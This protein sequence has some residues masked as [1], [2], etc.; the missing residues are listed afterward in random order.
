MKAIVISY[1]PLP[2]FQDEIRRKITAMDYGEIFMMQNQ[3]IALSFTN[4]EL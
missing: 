3:A 2:Y 4:E 1:Y